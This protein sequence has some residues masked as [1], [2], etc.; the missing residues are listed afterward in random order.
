MSSG[1]LPAIA[2][3][4]AGC[5]IVLACSRAPAPI[6]ESRTV[7]SDAL[8]VDTLYASM[9]GP[10]DIVRVHLTDST[11]RE[12]VWVVGYEASIVDAESREPMSSEYMC[13]SNADLDMARHRE[14]F[15]WTKYPS[16][17]LFTLS[18]GQ[19]EV[20][21]PQGFGVPL[22]ADEPLVVTAQVLNHNRAGPPV[23]VR[24]KITVHFVR[25]RSLRKPLVPLYKSSVTSLVRLAGPGGGYGAP[26]DG[27]AHDGHAGHDAP[28]GIPAD[29][30][31]YQDRAGR[32]FAGHW[33]V[34]P[35][36]EVRRTPVTRW[37]DLA[38]DQT[39]HFVSVHLHPFATSLELR[40]ATTGETVLAS[41]A[42]N[43][44][45]RVGL[46]HVE[47]VAA[48]AGIPLRKGHEYELVSAYDNTSAVN[49]TAMAVMY[50]YLRDTEFRKPDSGEARAR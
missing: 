47:Q 16:R 39:V 19:S 26:A 45:G 29:T 23:R 30:Y 3:W 15:G 11:S 5:T 12:L 32:T 50:L 2:P 27:H 33:V 10:Y 46:A 6:V 34:K 14:I 35:G 41:R 13:H 31:P 21:F 49:R 42:T 1:R 28:E 44:A 22:R 18:E 17:R 8:T 36:R 43:Q 38:E 9:Q 48:P 20:R 7:Y 24:Q 25:D 40:D 4:I 37:L